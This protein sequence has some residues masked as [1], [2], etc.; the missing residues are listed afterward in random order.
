MEMSGTRR[1]S[2]CVAI[3]MYRRFLC[4]GFCVWVFVCGFLGG[5]GFVVV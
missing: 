5:M 2:A 3:V 1:R 4:V